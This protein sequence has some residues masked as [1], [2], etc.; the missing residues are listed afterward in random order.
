MKIC[1]DKNTLNGTSQPICMIRR[2]LPSLHILSAFFGGGG[3]GV[4]GLSQT[5]NA[6]EVLEEGFYDR[7][8]PM[9]IFPDI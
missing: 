3:G 8:M 7:I 1:S 4:V 5:N 2:Y 9:R 6:G